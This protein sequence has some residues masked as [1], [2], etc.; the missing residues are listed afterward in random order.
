MLPRDSRLDPRDSRLGPRDS[1][2][3][4]RA[5]AA[6]LRL[7]AVAAAAALSAHRGLSEG[8]GFGAEQR[9]GAGTP[10][11]GGPASV[12]VCEPEAVG[13]SKARGTRTAEAGRLGPLVPAIQRVKGPP[14][15]V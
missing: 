9:L 10:R 8:Q 11:A 14:A 2:G 15:E 3:E 13:G 7:C 5:R 4:T 12:C 1:R 6:L